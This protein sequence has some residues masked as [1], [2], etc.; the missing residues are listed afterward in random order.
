M[1]KNLKGRELGK[2]ITQRKDGR[3]VARFV[4]I[5][6]VRVE[7]KFLSLQ[8]ARAWLAKAREE[9]KNGGRLEPNSFAKVNDWYEYWM[10]NIKEKT[11]R[12]NTSRNY[13]DRYY[14]NIKPQI[15]NMFLQDVKP[16]HC[17]RVLNMMEKRYSGSTIYQTYIT[18]NNMFNAA[19]EN[20]LIEKNPMTRSVKL[21]KPV[22][23][24][25]KFLSVEEQDKFLK[26]AR[27]SSKNY[28]QYLFILNTGTRTG[29]MV[30]L[31]WEDLDFDN[32][33]IS[34]KRTMEFRYSVGEWTVGPPKTKTSA[35]E[36][37]MT[38][39]V[40]EMLLNIKKELDNGKH[41]EEKFKEYV[42]LNSHGMPT[43]NST[44]DNDLTKITNLAGIQNISM[45][46]LRHTFATRCV[47]A[48]MKPKTLQMIL[49]HAN[50]NVT[51]N[52]YVHL[53]DEEKVKEM[54]KFEIYSD[55]ISN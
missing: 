23:K 43:K 20:E 38:Q 36:I 29:E 2:G 22:V 30:G 52:L 39:T 42:F 6:G 28:R 3:Y 34:I 4:A 25:N 26:A 7:K 53:T 45:H 15:G 21:P 33:K 31:K 24:R 50:I 5:R 27:R 19:L 35:R 8:D 44:Y 48:G 51:M 17:Q 12:P 11:V 55:S 18:L 14:M 54:E 49:G 13:K 47:E 9:D 1:G 41:V 10:D 40:K 16:M 46:T 32:S 37:P